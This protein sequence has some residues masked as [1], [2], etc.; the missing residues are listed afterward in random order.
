MLSKKLDDY[1]IVCLNEAFH[2]GSYTVKEFIKSMKSRG[3]QYIVSSKSVKFI[4]K[5]L[6]DSGVLILSKLP[7]TETSDITYESG[8]SYDDFAAKGSVYA[9]IQINPNDSINVFSTHLQASYGS[10]TETDYSVRSDQLRALNEFMV[11]HQN[12]NSPMILLGD[13]NINSIGEGKEYV[14]MLD[15]LKIDNFE[16]I[17]TLKVSNGEHLSTTSVLNQPGDKELMTNESIDYIMLFKHK[18]DEVIKGFNTTVKKFKI[19]N[20]AYPYL[21]DHFAVESTIELK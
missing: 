5:R 9:K 3:F 17:D 1:D 10:V 21:S 18:N 11:Q 13:L 15:T 12:G 2:F 8:C 20:F 7:I 14:H 16:L 19:R 6:I 4:S